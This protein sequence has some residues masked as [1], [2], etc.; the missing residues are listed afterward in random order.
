MKKLLLLALLLSSAVRA[1][2]EMKEGQ[3]YCDD[4]EAVKSNH[5]LLAKNPNDPLIIRLVALRA[6]LC[7]LVDE[8][9]ISLDQAID[10]F[11]DEKNRTVVE[12]S[13]E[14]LAHQPSPAT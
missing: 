13:K 7:A 2:I 4:P 6:G 5:D 3:N 1:E 8:K 12:R 11:T 10:I 14:E 9:K